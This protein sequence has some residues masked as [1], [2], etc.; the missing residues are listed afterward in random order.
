MKEILAPN[1]VTQFDNSLFLAGSIDMGNAENWQQRI[2]TDLEHCEGIILNPR[3]TDW[4]S[5]WEQ[6]I[7][8]PQFNEQVTWELDGLTKANT[9]FFYFD[10]NGLAP[11]TLMELGYVI[12]KNNIIVC[13]PDGYWRKGNVEII[14]NRHGITVHNTYEDA[15]V[16][17][18][19]YFS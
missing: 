6:S 17:L 3:R 15:L 14:C 19:K 12:Q 18:F 7:N 1:P 11:I 5:S 4:D 13:C 16:D 8:N 10:P 2:V 9:I